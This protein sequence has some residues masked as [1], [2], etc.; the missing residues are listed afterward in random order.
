METQLYAAFDALEDRHWW[1][2]G[3]RAI[4][5]A[6]LARRLDRAPRREI[7]DVGCGTG[8]MLPLLAELGH[9][10]GLEAAPS[11][12]ACA[13]RRAPG[14]PVHLGGLPGGL[15]AD[16]TWDLVTAFDVLEH[17]EDPVA[18]LLAIHAALRPGGQLVCTVPAFPFL[19]SEHDEVNRHFRRYRRRSLLAELETAR[20]EVEWSSYFNTF[21]FPP[22]ALA[23]LAR[24][25]V[26]ARGGGSD[27]VPTAPLLNRALHALFASE[28]HLVPHVSLPF[29]VSLLAVARRP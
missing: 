24:R 16:R 10:E 25:L 5:R 17:L 11:A 13:R 28:R 22:V 6:V 18:T 1:F 12:V 15:P 3:R 29:G 2:Q 9:V 14:T 19:W 21:L 23:R 26:P 8:G 27:I 4:V 7:L 20:F